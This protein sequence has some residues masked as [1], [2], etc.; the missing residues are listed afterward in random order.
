M[1]FVV[2]LPSLARLEGGGC[3]PEDSACRLQQ[4]TLKEENMQRGG[5]GDRGE[6]GDRN[7]EWP[8]PRSEII[9][10]VECQI[11]FRNICQMECQKICQIECRIVCQIECQI[12]CQNVCPNICLEMNWWGSLEVKYFLCCFF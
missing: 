9:C 8:G 10:H 2:L 3:E 12:D 6:R 4:P 11:E 7:D 1:A 5:R